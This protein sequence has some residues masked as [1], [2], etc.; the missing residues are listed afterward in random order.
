[1]EREARTGRVRLRVA[2]VLCASLLASAWA[3]AAE[4]G[5]AAPAPDAGPPLR[6]GGDARYPPYHF[7][8]AR[9]HADGFDVALARA[10]ASDMGREAVFELGA[11][12]VALERLE[13]GELDVVPMFWSAE[14]E[15]RYGLSQ[16]LLLRHHALFGHFETPTVPSLDALADVR[17]AVQHAGLAWEAMR[18]LDRPGVTL[19][20]LD[21]EAATLELVA[22]GLADYALAPTG[23]GY[24]AIEE[25][26]VEGVVALSPPLLEREYVFAVRP[27]DPALVAGIDASLERLRREG[28]Q[29]RLYVD[30]IGSPAL[31]ARTQQGRSAAV[32]A[33]IVALLALALAVAAILAWR[34]SAAR[35]ARAR[36]TAPARVADP[37]LLAELNEA[38]AAGTLGFVLQPKIDLRSG[39][40]IGAELLVRWDHP[41]RGRLEP[42]DFVPLAEE[43]RI[44]GDMTLYLVRRGLDQCWD[45]PERGEPLHVAVNVS[46]DDLADPELVDAIIAATRG[47]GARLM[48]EITETGIMREPARV[49]AALPRLRRHGIRISVDDFG[50]GHSSLVKLRR[51]APDELKIDRA[52]VHALQA[53]RSD[54]AIVRST[55]ALAHELGARVAAEGVEDEA[56]RQWLA[57]AGCDVAQGF[58]LARPMPPAD[59]LAQLHARA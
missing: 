37:G 14:R 7:L 41:S 38:I 8:D 35:E 6:F 50:V 9:G 1:M 13:R 55:I 47:M 11:W 44:I 5:R 58:G 18:E 34:R 33:G 19:V 27:G 43:A 40:W 30:W 28:V 3:L 51:L 59:F 29:N 45:W 32:T 49:A 25:G 15:R 53:S 12:D 20:E 2:A 54:R 56:T 16:P 46:A 4:A 57:E 17:V 24:H 31:R 22:R 26:A 48:L 21:N 42:E 10:V 39:R 23:I 36:Q 52:F